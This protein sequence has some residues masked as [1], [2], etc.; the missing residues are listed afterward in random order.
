MADN[1][2]AGL[3][4]DLVLKAKQLCMEIEDASG[5]PQ[6]ERNPTQISET[7]Q[8]LKDKINQ[9]IDQRKDEKATT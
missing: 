9:E 7:I 1:V 8:D 5:L 6:L 3:F 2:N 4:D